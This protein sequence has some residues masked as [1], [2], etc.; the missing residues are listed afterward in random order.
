MYNNKEISLLSREELIKALQKYHLKCGPITRT[1][2]KIFENRL[3]AYLENCNVGVESKED[4]ENWNIEEIKS[5][6][7]FNGCHD[8]LKIEENGVGIKKTNS[9]DYHLVSGKTNN[10][11][12][13]RTEVTLISTETL[14]FSDTQDAKLMNGPSPDTDINSPNQNET[15][16]NIVF[17]EL[18]NAEPTKIVKF[19]K[20]VV[21]HCVLD[22]SDSGPTYN[23][24]KYVKRIDQVNPDVNI[25]VNVSK[26]EIDLTVGNTFVSDNSLDNVIPSG[27]IEN[28]ANSLEE[29]Q[30]NINENSN[31][32]KSD[33]SISPINGVIPVTSVTKSETQL[34][35]KENEKT[36]STTEFANNKSPEKM[37]IESISDKI[38]E[39]NNIDSTSCKLPEKPVKPF[40]YGIWIPHST[41]RVN[42]SK[43]IVCESQKEALQ[44][45][46]D[47]KGSRFK[48]FECKKDAEKFSLSRTIQSCEKKAPSPPLTTP[49]TSYSVKDEPKERPLKC[50]SFQEIIKF[51]QHIEKFKTDEIEACLDRPRYLVSANDIPVILQ[52][53]SRMNAV[54]IATKCNRVKVLKMIFST[55]QSRE[56]LQLAYFNAADDHLEFRKNHLLDLYLNTPEKIVGTFFTFHRILSALCYI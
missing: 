29:K 10:D 27:V 3:R 19:D 43:A 28:D 21:A 51:R 39:T 36:A 47:F 46:K 45:M 44:Q 56:F 53:G 16:K 34:S 26:S 15:K 33:K 32:D 38:P 12:S 4:K 54:H 22:S 31:D 20:T 30:N 6:N 52:E 2:R 24:D 37:N 48:V 8:S 40:Y 35:D 13:Y 25:F 17:N 42:G 49:A 14:K 1:T 11:K 55:L 9:F 7:G 41:A 23:T 5:Y 50:P 18:Q